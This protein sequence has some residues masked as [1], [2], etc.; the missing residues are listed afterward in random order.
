MLTRAVQLK[1]VFPVSKVTSLVPQVKY[2]HLVCAG[3]KLHEALLEAGNEG[4]PDLVHKY[5]QE[6]QLM[7]NLCHPNITQFL[8]LCFLPNIRLPLLVMEKLETSLDDLLEHIPNLPLSLKHSILEGVASGLV[9]LH[10][11]KPPVIHRDLT[12]KNILLTSSL[13]AKITDMG[14][15]RIIDMRPGQLA[16]TLSKLPGTLVYM[17][18]EALSD[19]HRYGPSLDIF[20][21]GH[22]TL[23]TVTQVD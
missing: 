2:Q 5:L 6:C 22:L 16:R 19:T 10:K 18:P 17:P 23:Y 1:Q 12:A 21:F 11:R 7:S 20:S 3:K 14:N 13:Q 9:Y 15:S 4:V 8:G